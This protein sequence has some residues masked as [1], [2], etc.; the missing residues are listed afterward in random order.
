V[1]RGRP[2]FIELAFLLQRRLVFALQLSV[3]R[4]AALCGADWMDGKGIVWPVGA[5]MTNRLRGGGARGTKARAV[6]A[7]AQAGMFD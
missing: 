4:G 1:T 2:A 3:F 7:P 6:E 5:Y